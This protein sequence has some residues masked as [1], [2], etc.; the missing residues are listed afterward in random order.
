MMQ[1]LINYN[2]LNDSF[3]KTLIFHLGKNAGF[4]SEYNGMILTMLYCLQNKIKFVLYSKDAN[5]GFKNGWTDYFEPFCSETINIIHKYLNIRTFETGKVRFADFN[6]LKWHVKMAVFSALYAAIKPFK[7]TLFT[8]DIW[9]EVWNKNLLN[10]NF[11]FPELGIN[12]GFIHACNKLIELTYRFNTDVK[13]EIFSIIE[14]TGLPEKYI[15][16]HIRRGD[17]S[18]EADLIPVEKYIEE[19]KTLP[20]KDVFVST[21]DYSVYK[22][23]ACNFLQWNWITL[24]EE[25]EAG[26]NQ[27][28]FN[29]LDAKSKK[30]AIIRLLAEV[31]IWS[32][33]DVFIGTETSNLDIFLSR[34]KPDITKLVD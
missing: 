22:T 23:L 8:Q 9:A 17:K 12:G 34:Y 27:V 33:S 28:S 32:L 30:R 5:F 24:C 19:L 26:Y 1:T 2:K 16:C 15:A 10:Q 20:I 25:K 11:Y 18:I 4:Y 13:K 3:K 21:D 29:Y 31:N 14:K 6:F 7:S